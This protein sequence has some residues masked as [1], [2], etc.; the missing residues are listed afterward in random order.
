MVFAFAIVVMAAVVAV[1]LAAV[2]AVALALVDG[3][4]IVSVVIDIFP[5]VL[6]INLAVAV[7]KK[8]FLL[9]LLFLLSLPFLVVRH[10]KCNEQNE[11]TQDYIYIY[12]LISYKNVLANSQYPPPE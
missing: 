11:H 3:R 9:L 4:I 8:M 6:T 1:V 5:A 10:C 2:A 12:T 7:V